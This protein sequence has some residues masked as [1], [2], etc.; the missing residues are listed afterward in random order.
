MHCVW[1]IQFFAQKKSR[2]KNT[3]WRA[4]KTISFTISVSSI[5][6]FNQICRQTWRPTY[7]LLLILFNKNNKSGRRNQFDI[8]CIDYQIKL[9]DMPWMK[10]YG[11]IN[12]HIYIIP[13][14]YLG[15]KSTG[16]AF[17][18]KHF[19]IQRDTYEQN[20]TEHFSFYSYIDDQQMYKQNWL[21]NLYTLKGTDWFTIWISEEMKP[22]K[23]EI[24]PIFNVI[25]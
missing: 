12:L 19:I 5:Q 10:W 16:F 2:K 6:F 11:F 25:I 7:I 24:K 23:P 17:H 3:F 9:R 14:I 8:W 22:L 15:N 4:A 18:I 1:K 20:Q 13:C 21:N